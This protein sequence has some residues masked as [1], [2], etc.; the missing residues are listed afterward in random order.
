MYIRHRFV[1]NSSSTGFVAWG[2]IV[3]TSE[4]QE[5]DDLNLEGI[6]LHS[7]GLDKTAICVYFSLKHTST[8]DENEYLY[9]DEGVCSP[10]KEKSGWFIPASLKVPVK[11][12]RD[13]YFAWAK[14]LLGFLEEY[15]IVPD[16]IPGW[17]YVRER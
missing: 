6:E 2:V 17:F 9:F 13:G 1:T 5:I 12:P 14:I 15:K 11:E 16:G 7:V 8:D 4:V 3:P 10:I